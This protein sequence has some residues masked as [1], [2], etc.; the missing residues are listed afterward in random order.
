MA[1]LIRAEL[2]SHC[3][4]ASKAYEATETFDTT[5]VKEELAGPTRICI[6]VQTHAQH[7][8]LPGA[9]RMI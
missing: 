4:E 3:Q 8:A 9:W 6:R 7:F 1:K 5:S 2:V